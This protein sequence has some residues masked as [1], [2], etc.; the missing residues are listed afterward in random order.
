M[1]PLKS[2]IVHSFS[3]LNEIYD[4]MDASNWKKATKIIAGLWQRHSRDSEL[5]ALRAIALQKTG[6]GAEA[7]ATVEPLVAD[8]AI[9]S[10]VRSLVE[11]VLVWEKRDDLL[12]SLYEAAYGS[13]QDE[14]SLSRLFHAM[15][16][17]GMHLKQQQTAMRYVLW[18]SL[19]FFL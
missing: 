4:A 8:R 9:D 2:I 6:E 3:Q 11:R 19:W 1:A 18:H 15:S 10:H 5:R 17:L 13:K 12:A 7:L 14:E 16:G